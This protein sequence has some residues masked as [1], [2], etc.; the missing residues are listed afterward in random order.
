MIRSPQTH[1]MKARDL[2]RI[3]MVAIMHRNRYNAP[4][5]LCEHEAFSGRCRR[6]LATESDPDL[7]Q[8]V[9]IG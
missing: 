2:L 7:R 1:H 8:A 6:R 9:A 3:D 5:Q 4:V